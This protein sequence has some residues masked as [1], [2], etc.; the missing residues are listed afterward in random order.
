MPSRTMYFVVPGDLETRTG[1]YGFDR[2]VVAGLRERGWTVVVVSLPGNYPLATAA[3]RLAAARAFAAIPSDALVVVDGLALGALAAEAVHERTR[4]RLIALVHHPL[5]L[6]TGIDAA[7]SNRLLASEREALTAVRGVVVTSRRTMGAVERLGVPSTSLAVVEPGTVPMPLAAGSG[8]A[9][10]EWL[11]VASLVPR[12]GHDTLFDAL[13]TLTALPWHLTCVGGLNRDSD[14][15]SRLVQRSSSGSLSGRV[16]LAGELAGAALDSAYDRADVFVLATH[17]EGYGMAVAEAL[18]RG[19]PVVST[20]TGAIEELVGRSAGILVPPAD[21]AAL[22]RELRRVIT[23][24]DVLEQL[25]RGARAVRAS[26][27]TWDAACARMEAALLA[28]G[29]R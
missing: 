12:K 23:D 22:A 25:R 24:R 9:R 3:A 17:Y 11:C 13:E 4:L 28:F 20:P 10:L 18:A 14:F 15:A 21:P 5:G 29:D 16:T 19:I 7:T 27:P 1:G 8:G 6:E 26:L 2:A